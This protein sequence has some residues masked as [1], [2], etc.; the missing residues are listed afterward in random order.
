MFS[1]KHGSNWDAFWV[2]FE[3]MAKR[4]GWPLQKQ[5]EQLLFCLKDEAMDFAVGLSPEVCEDL[6]LFLEALRKRFSHTTTPAETVRANLN[7][8]RKKAKE[9]MQEYA[10]IVRTM[11]TR[12]YPDIGT[13][14]TFTRLTIHN[15][16]QGLHDQSVVYEVLKNRPKTL[17][18]AINMVTW[19]ECCKEET[20]IKSGV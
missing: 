17:T 2:T 8:L 5:S 15:L 14:E 16:L 13:S 20:H 18:E 19:H 11:I 7:S 9:T 10:S 12:A 3:L 1:G 6:M 4:Y